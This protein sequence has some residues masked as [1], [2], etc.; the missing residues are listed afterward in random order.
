MIYIPPELKIFCKECKMLTLHK[1][2]GIIR[3]KFSYECSICGRVVIL[4]SDE[5][6]FWETHFK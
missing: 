3:D 6:R 5:I 4:D 2:S 1:L